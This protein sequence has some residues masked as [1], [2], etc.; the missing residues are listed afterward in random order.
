MQLLSWVGCTFYGY[1]DLML[2][3]FLFMGSFMDFYLQLE[4]DTGCGVAVARRLTSL[5]EPVVVSSI[6]MDHRNFFIVLLNFF[7]RFNKL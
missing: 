3:R 6:E 7:A 2:G 5:F 1:R 4:C